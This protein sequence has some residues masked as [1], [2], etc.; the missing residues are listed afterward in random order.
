MTVV[1]NHGTEIFYEVTG[2]GPP[3]VLQHGRMG[4]GRVWHDLGYTAA[5][6]DRT[7]ILID[8][9]GHGRSDKPRDPDAYHS[10]DV[11]TDVVRVLDDIAV[12][13][14][15]FFGYSMGGRIGFSAVAH[16]PDRFNSLIAGGSGP[17][18]PGISREAELELADTLGDGVEAYVSAMEAMLQRTVPPGDRAVLLANDA[19]ALAA[20]ARATADWPDVTGPVADSEVPIQLFGG[21][22]DPIWPLIERAHGMLSA[23]ELRCFDRLGHGE[24]LRQPELV[25]PVVIDF[26]QRRGLPAT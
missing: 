15:D 17:H 22:A 11:A 13:R 8:A 10:S 19:E 2:T 4:S 9:R 3:L 6:A 20:L 16:F 7:L 12:D 18:G 26:L 5:L 1:D 14:A 24:D 25:L 21:G 23:S